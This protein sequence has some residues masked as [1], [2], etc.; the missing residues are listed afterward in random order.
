MTDFDPTPA[1]AAVED[2]RQRWKGRTDTFS[3]VY[4]TILGVDEFT[5]Y[6]EIAEIANCSPNTAKKHLNRLVEMRI[7]Q[8]DTNVRSARYRR[9]DAYLEWYEASQIAEEFPEGKI[10]D[11]VRQFESRIQ[12]Y[13]EEFDTD[14]PSTI[15]V[16]DQSDHETVH[17]RMEA[18]SEWLSL[19]R[20]IHLYE[21]AHQLAAN[22]GHLISA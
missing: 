2:A 20:D 9:N 3:R 16:R 21:L 14:D 12:E 7:V 4:N 10:I 6:P 11:R 13:E 15:S 19:E 5:H 22:D 8:Q 1:E 17:E 18:I